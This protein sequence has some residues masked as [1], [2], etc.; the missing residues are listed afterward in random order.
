MI[1]LLQIVIF[2]SYVGLPEGICNYLD[3]YSP[4]GTNSA[5]LG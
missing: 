5:I 4:T 3:K 1:Y 2:N